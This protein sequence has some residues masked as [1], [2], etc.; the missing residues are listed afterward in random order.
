MTYCIFFSLFP[1]RFSWYRQ[2]SGGLYY[3]TIRNLLYCERKIKLMML[4]RDGVTI[5]TIAKQ[6]PKNEATSEIDRDALV[7]IIKDHIEDFDDLSH[8]DADVIFSVCGY[9]SR[10]VECDC[11]DAA[12]ASELSNLL[13]FDRSHFDSMSRG[14]WTEPH[15]VVLLLCTLAT[16]AFNHLTS[17]AN[18]DVFLGV[19]NHRASFVDAV[20]IVL[21]GVLPNLNECTHIKRILSI[22][23]NI[24][25]KNYIRNVNS[26]VFHSQSVRKINKLLSRSA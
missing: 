1:F 16:I 17:G 15:P 3:I 24:L 25:T 4:L 13:E 7:S 5:S 19:H 8:K 6:I 20:I 26:K 23:F 9:V 2:S 22:Y 14:G 21:R 18:R 11:F 10:Y 12:E